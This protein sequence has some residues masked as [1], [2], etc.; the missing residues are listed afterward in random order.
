MDTLLGIDLGTTG[1]KAAL[2][3][4]RG[5]L[6]G[7]SYLEYPLIRPEPGVVEQDADL[8]WVLAQDAIGQAMR[9]A[10]VEGDT[11]RVVVDQRDMIHIV[12]SNGYLVLEGLLLMTGQA[13]FLHRR[14]STN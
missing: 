12:I 10:Q 4:P 1:I 9:A 5:L 8:W 11:V 7:D 6:L 2:C 13:I 3:T 14:E